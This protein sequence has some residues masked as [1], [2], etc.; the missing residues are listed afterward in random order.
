MR[1]EIINSRDSL[2]S[3]N[4]RAMI[5]KKTSRISMNTAS[6]Q[7]TFPEAYQEILA[8]CSTVVSSPRHF[9]LSGGEAVRFGSISLR[10]HVPIRTFVGI[11][12][13]SEMRIAFG[14]VRSFVPHVQRF[15]ESQINPQVQ[16]VF[17]SQLI[18]YFSKNGHTLPHG[19]IL[20]V[21]FELPQ[22]R[23]GGPS[24]TLVASALTALLLEQG[25]LTQNDIEQWKKKTGRELFAP[26]SS[27]LRH[28][29][30][31][32]GFHSI[33]YPWISGSSA[34]ITMINSDYPIL[35]FSGHHWSDDSPAHEMLKRVGARPSGD[36][37]SIQAY[38][39]HEL[40]GNR[41]PG[42]PF[43]FGVI[44]TG[45]TINT[46]DKMLNLDSLSNRLVRSARFAR[47]LLSEHIPKS[48]YWESLIYRLI[49]TNRRDE[50]WKNYLTSWIM[51]DIMV[52]QALKNCFQYGFNDEIATEL[53]QLYHNE[54]FFLRLFGWQSGKLGDV[55]ESVRDYLRKRGELFGLY[56][57]AYVQY[58]ELLFITKTG[59]VRDEINQ[60]IQRL[61][62]KHNRT[63]SLDYASWLDG[64]ET[65]GLRVE[66]LVRERMYS[67][68]LSRDGVHLVVWRR[69]GQSH[70]RYIQPDERRSINGQYDIVLDSVD[71]R[72]YVA[73]KPL[74]SK[75]LHSQRGSIETL[76]ILLDNYGHV[77]L[78]SAFS[79]SAYRDRNEMQSKIISPIQ[80]VVQT[81]LRRSIPLELTGGLGSKYTLRLK[82]SSLTFALL[83]RLE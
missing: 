70:V 28:C 4:V 72:M 78:G 68:L 36:V 9:S 60:L 31:V 83:K 53:A 39:L 76:R 63:I 23:G 1:L 67:P 14:L 37:R 22:E 50:L 46:V 38:R 32:V 45:I 62:R 7:Q 51:N 6:L 58:G 77:V 5:K 33:I 21:I 16:K 49:N 35:S 40:I 66:Q 41:L 55:I 57:D 15:I 8:R 61:R 11:E 29:N 82:P 64:F 34:T 43:D 27:F 59:Q 24:G 3:G 65:D 52:L 20:H 75:H 19:Y 42:W 13:V 25:K 2:E 71:Q 56:L 74:S 73:G 81:R 30:F 44:S 18:D 79:S 10:Q 12:P 26:D 48:Y 80:K 69:S 54:Y 17:E 47:A